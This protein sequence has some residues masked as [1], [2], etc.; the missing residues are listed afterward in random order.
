MSAAD[1][2]GPLAIS[3]VNLID[4]CFA[5]TNTSEADVACDGWKVHDE[6]VETGAGKRNV[7]SFDKSCPGLVLGAGQTVRVYSGPGSK[8]A[9]EYDNQTEVHWFSYA[10]WDDSGDAAYLTNPEGT[11]IHTFS[12][13]STPTGADGETAPAYEGDKEKDA[14]RT[15]GMELTGECKWYHFQKGFG[16]ISKLSDGGS[17]VFVHH[18]AVTAHEGQQPSLTPGMRLKFKF[19][20]DKDGRARA[21]EVTA[22]DGTAVR[23]HA[24]RRN[25]ISVAR[26]AERPDVKLGWCKWFDKT[27]GYGFITPENPE[28]AE[29]FCHQKA[30][31]FKDSNQLIIAGQDLEYMVTTEEK[32]GKVSVRASDVTGPG[33]QPVACFGAGD[34]GGLGTLLGKRSAASAL[35]QP[36]QGN[37]RMGMQPVPMGMGGLLPRGVPAVRSAMRQQQ[38]GLPM[39]GGMGMGM[40]APGG[41]AGYN[42]GFLQGLN[43][44]QQPSLM[45][46]QQRRY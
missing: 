41:M 8:E 19:T 44:M 9:R 37:G 11:L 46:F 36:Q 25:P 10:V 18:S 20:L 22:E 12:N 31:T 24:S 4:E 5:V 26:L 39:A 27:K 45:Q 40:G 23:T 33:G 6:K 30:V 16:F 43:A 21:I 1:S 32:D 2:T 28:D 34:V 42:A 35:L 14:E 38:Q 3:E 13:G 17:E 7:F 15:E 29:V